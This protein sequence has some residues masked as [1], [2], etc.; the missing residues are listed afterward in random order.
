LRDF[1][2]EGFTGTPLLTLG[3]IPLRWHRVLTVSPPPLESLPPFVRIARPPLDAA[4]AREYLERVKDAEHSP[5][6]L[7]EI[8]RFRDRTERLL[9]EA[10]PA[11]P[12]PDRLG[13]GEGN[14]DGSMGAFPDASYEGIPRDPPLR[15]D[16][17]TPLQRPA[18]RSPLGFL[19]QGGR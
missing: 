1:I 12:I 16:P 18:Y 17:G 11:D 4:T 8:Q 10:P 6:L 13:E 19:Q 9:S 15:D 7:R 2:E 5:A 3:D 14:P